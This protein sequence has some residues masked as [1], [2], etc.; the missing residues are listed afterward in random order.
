MVGVDR[1][2]QLGYEGQCFHPCEAHHRAAL[3]I[4]R[5]AHEDALVV[6]EATDAEDNGLALVA[7]GLHAGA[8]AVLAE[9]GDH[10][11]A[12]GAERNVPVLIVDHGSSP[13]CIRASTATTCAAPPRSRSR[14]VK[15]C[16]RQGCVVP[17]GGGWQSRTSDGPS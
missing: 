6:G 12:L 15:Q 8:V 2:A 17:G 5:D 13:R 7:Q 16:R 10:G 3:A 1:R 4:E 14:A 9:A 11:A